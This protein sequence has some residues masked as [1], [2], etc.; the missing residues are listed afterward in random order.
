M[1]SSNLLSSYFFVKWLST[2]ERGSCLHAIRGICPQGNLSYSWI[3]LI[4]SLFLMYKART[5]EYTLNILK[6][7][8]SDFF[9]INVPW[10]F[11]KFW[12]QCPNSCPTFLT[13]ILSIYSMKLW[14]TITS[15]VIYFS[16]CVCLWENNTDLINSQKWSGIRRGCME[17]MICVPLGSELWY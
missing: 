10:F 3:C 4:N 7:G 9:D 16:L 13:Q 5:V 12:Y 15:I 11:L 17:N 14:I 6:L 2:R 1:K 8:H